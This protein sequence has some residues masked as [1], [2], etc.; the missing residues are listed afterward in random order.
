MAAAYMRAMNEERSAGFNLPRRGN[1]RSNAVHG[2]VGENDH[3]GQVEDLSTEE[4]HTKLFE[5]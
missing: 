5:T 4:S 3:R 1:V 2:I